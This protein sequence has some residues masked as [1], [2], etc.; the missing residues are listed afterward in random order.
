MV[1]KYHTPVESN[2]GPC[3]KRPTTNKRH[4]F[5]KANYVGERLCVY[6]GKA[7]LEEPLCHDCVERVALTG[8]NYC[9]VCTE[10][11]E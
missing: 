9:S 11:H 10:H 8:T 5:D 6:C 2:D 4:V 7:R 1:K 3:P